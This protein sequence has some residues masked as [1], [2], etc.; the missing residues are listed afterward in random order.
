MFKFFISLEDCWFTIVP[1]QGYSKLYSFFS[2][3]SH[4]LS[5]TLSRVPS[6]LH[7]RSFLVIY[8]IRA[9]WVC[10]SH[11]LIYPSLHFPFGTHTF[12][13][14]ICKS[15]SIL[16]I[17]TFISFLKLNSPYNVISYDIC[18]SAS[19]LLHLVCLSLGP[20]MLLHVSRRQS[21]KSGE[22]VSYLYLHVTCH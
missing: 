7:S 9:V 10:S 21:Q 4:R 20:A 11:Y 15:V 19:D 3:F 13:F 17:S 16:Y 5:Q 22:Y 12:V 6:V 2:F 18:L 1:F 14:K 8:L